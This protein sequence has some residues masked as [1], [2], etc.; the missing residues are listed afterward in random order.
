MF[1]GIL[2]LHITAVVVFLFIYLVKT[3]LLLVNANDGLKNFSQKTKIAE[4]VVS[5]IFLL[6]GIYLW[7]NSGNTGTW[8]YVKVIAVL[9]AIPLA[10]IG[11]KRQNKLLAALSFILIVYAYGVAETKSP[12]F[13]KQATEAAGEVMKPA[14]PLELGKAAYDNYCANC[15]GT[16]GK[17]GLSGAKDLSISTL[18]SNSVKTI[19]ANGKGQMMPF[20]GTLNAAEVDAVSKFV[21]TFRK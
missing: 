16:D 5:T 1:K 10:V 17:L 21:V 18:D 19:V 8:L 3:I 4:M 12:I 15:H 14:N 6:T 9:I 20:K 13:K 11:F 7:M 2:H